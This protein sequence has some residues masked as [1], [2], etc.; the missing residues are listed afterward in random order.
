MNSAEF[1]KYLES[2]GGVVYAGE[3]TTSRRKFEIHNGWL[4]IVASAFDKAIALGWNKQVSQV[5]EK[6]GY[7]CI[8]G[9]WDLPEISDVFEDAELSACS[10]CEVCG[11]PGE[12]RS[13]RSW[14]RTLCERCD[15][16]VRK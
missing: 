13:N 8:Y 9:R 4:S 7:L 3:V 1:E 15:F 12:L 5:K 10:I 14:H 2:I 6:F 11:D 16:L